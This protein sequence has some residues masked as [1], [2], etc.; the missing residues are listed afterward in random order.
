MMQRTQRA[1]RSP[2]ALTR[3]LLGRDLRRTTVAEAEALHLP[4]A[5]HPGPPVTA[6]H[7]AH[8]PA[9]VQRYL[10][11]VGVVGRP[12]DWSF[13]ARFTGRFRMRPGQRFM[14]CEAWQYSSALEVATYAEFEFPPG[15]I[16][17]NISPG[18][19]DGSGAERL[20]SAVESG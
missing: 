14:P 15:D 7:I 11:F 4:P 9:V 19:L 17:Y 5:P 6:A 18:D 3:R 8:L 2:L 1:L 13:G 20:T 16:R 10:T 12:V